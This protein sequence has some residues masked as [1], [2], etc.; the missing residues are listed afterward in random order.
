MYLRIATVLFAA[1]LAS[2]NSQH[3]PLCF[4][5]KVD[6]V[7]VVDVSG[8]AEERFIANRDSAIE[9]AKALPISWE[10]VGIAIIQFSKT[11]IMRLEFGTS[12]NWE[13]VNDTLAN[14]EWTGDVA[15]SAEA[16][17][18]AMIM[19]RRARP[20]A[21]RVIILFSDGNSFNTWGEV[22]ETAERLHYSKA[23]IFAVSLSG[24]TY[25]TELKQYVDF[26]NGS[27]IRRQSEFQMLKKELLDMTVPRCPPPAPPPQDFLRPAEANP[28]L[29]NQ[30]PTRRTSRRSGI[31]RAI[32]TTTT[33]PTPPRPPPP[34]L[35]NQA[36]AAAAVNID[37]PLVAPIDKHRTV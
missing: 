33:R 25:E 4:S 20:D 12:V 5:G 24:N 8:S 34:P 30:L 10:K 13:V 18:L 26:S 37:G 21:Q 9:I 16:M 19:F 23:K 28:D 7:M 2:V 14:M 35:P 32:R 6:I 36:A 29:E 15:Q 22:T 1:T 17:D 31:T 3:A 27:I 11:A